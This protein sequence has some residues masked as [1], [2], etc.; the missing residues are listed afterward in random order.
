MKHIELRSRSIAK[1]I[2]WKIIALS[3]SWII[4]YLFLREAGESFKIAIVVAPVSLVA[5]Y[6]HERIWNRIHWGKET[7]NHHL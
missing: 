7:K 1:A 2:T 6:F 5:Y 3:L 4:L